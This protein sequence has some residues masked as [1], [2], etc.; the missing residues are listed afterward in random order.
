MRILLTADLHSRRDW[1]DWLLR[2]QV[3]LTVVA[4]DLLDGLR[5]DGLLVQMLELRRWCARF[6]GHLAVC[7]GNHDHNTPLRAQR[8]EALAGIP[9]DVREEVLSLLTAGH[10]MDCLESDRIVTDQRTKVV[11]TPGGGLV[12]TAVPYDFDGGDDHDDLWGDGAMLRDQQKIPW[13]VLH[14]EPPAEVKVGGRMGN[15]Q[16]YYK[17]QE[18]RP[19]F[20]VS[21]H[22]HNQPYVGSFADRL[23]G[24]WCFNPGLPEQ[25][26]A[27]Q[28]SIPNHIVLDLVARTA[29]WHASPNVGNLPITETISLRGFL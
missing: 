8:P 21:G 6:S 17:I 11:T 15:R 29:T 14:H 23:D 7:S 19:D 3:D 5:A 4:G 12:V 20:V 18:Y 25:S 10:W 9:D 13:L 28:S 26:L 16:L 27:M 1:F 2:Q 24:T 22:L